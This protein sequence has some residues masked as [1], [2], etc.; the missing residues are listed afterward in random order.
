M[1]RTNLGIVRTDLNAMWS[2]A[3]HDISIL[4]HWF[5]REPVSVGAEG[6]SRLQEGIEDVV[7]LTIRFQDDLLAHVHC[8]WLDPRKVREAT[9]VGSEKMVVYDDVST[10]AKVSL[11]DKG[12]V[13]SEPADQDRSADTRTSGASS[14]SL[15]P[16]TW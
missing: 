12:V 3:P 15:A 1:R 2:L 8:S 16:A 7:F 9:V 11:F 14:S 5:G 4:C 6:F 10:D 13:R